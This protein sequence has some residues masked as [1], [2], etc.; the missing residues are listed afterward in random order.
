MLATWVDGTRLVQIIRL[1]TSMLTTSSPVQPTL[2]RHGEAALRSGVSADEG[3]VLIKPTTRQKRSTQIEEEIA[4]TRKTF[5]QRAICYAEPQTS[6]VLRQQQQSRL[7]VM[8]LYTWTSADEFKSRV[9]VVNVKCLHSLSLY[10]NT[11]TLTDSS[12]AKFIQ[13]AHLR[14]EAVI[15]VAEY[16]MQTKILFIAKIAFDKMW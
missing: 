1:Q 6:D 7:F 2:V 13:L 9:T 10:M 4:L 5:Q 14:C 11:T 15:H 8:P 16:T 12:W 3:V